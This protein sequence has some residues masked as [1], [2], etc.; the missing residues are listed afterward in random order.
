MNLL[1]WRFQQCLGLFIILLVDR[2]CETRPFRELSEHVLCGLQVRKS[3]IS[4]EG[5]VFFK[6]FKFWSRF[7]KYSKKS[8]NC[9]CFLD[10]CIWIGSLKLSLLR[11]ECLSSTVNVLT[12]SPKTFVSLRKI[13]LNSIYLTV[14]N[15]YDKGTVIWV[16]TVFRIIYHYTCWRVLWNWTFY[17]FIWAHISCSITLEIH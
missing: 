14:I 7:Q 6:M 1:L 5:H 15:K 4:F 12:N 11:K 13:F 8:R 16:W 10:I 9:F 17:T 2:S 3:I